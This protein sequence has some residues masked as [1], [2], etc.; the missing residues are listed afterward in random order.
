MKIYLGYDTKNVLN[1]IK[2]LPKNSNL[3]FDILEIMKV[4]RSDEI[5]HYNKEIRFLH[6][7]GYLKYEDNKILIYDSFDDYVKLMEIYVRLL[8]SLNYVYKLYSNSILVIVLNAIYVKFS[9]EKKIIQTFIDNA[10]STICLGINH[11]LI[12]GGS[13]VKYK[14]E[15]LTRDV[16]KLLETYGE[17]TV[18]FKQLMKEYS[19]SLDNNDS[20]V[21][22]INDLRDS[23]VA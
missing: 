11:F 16:L 18:A 2:K 23:Y 4:R 15:I 21:R 10:L 22:E 1:E 3:N 5:E 14:H 13:N 12:D 19:K 9:I 6:D 8:D 20:F 7:N 17:S